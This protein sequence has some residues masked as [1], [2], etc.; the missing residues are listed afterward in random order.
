MGG[1]WGESEG[2]PVNMLIKGLFHYTG[3]QYM[4]PSHWSI[5]T[6]SVNT[7]VLVTLMRNVI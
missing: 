5:M 4:I 2:M 3:F 6:P 1:E 7:Q